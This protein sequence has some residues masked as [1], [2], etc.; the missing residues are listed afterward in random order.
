MTSLHRTELIFSKLSSREK[1]VRP[2]TI[3]SSIPMLA[4]WNNNKGITSKQ[5]IVMLI[6]LTA[7]V[8]CYAA[9]A[10]LPSTLK[11]NLAVLV[12]IGGD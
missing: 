11:S 10:N 12:L 4:Q 5:K 6:A 7:T 9:T 3:I 8:K 2:T 1:S